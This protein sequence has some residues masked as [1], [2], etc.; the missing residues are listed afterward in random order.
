MS[1]LSQFGGG[2][3]KSIQRGTITVNIAATNALSSATATITAV[4][5]AKSMVSLLGSTWPTTQGNLAFSRVDLT[6]GTTV[7]AFA[8]SG[9]TTGNFTVGYQVVEYL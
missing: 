4:D 3:I 2:G 8:G 5:P 1:I 7:T 9:F 6:N